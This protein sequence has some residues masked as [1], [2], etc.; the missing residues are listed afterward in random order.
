M[1]TLRDTSM[2]QVYWTVAIKMY[3]AVK[4]LKASLPNKNSNQQHPSTP[5]RGGDPI[6]WTKTSMTKLPQLLLDAHGFE[7]SMHGVHE[8]QQQYFVQWSIRPL[9]ELLQAYA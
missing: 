9:G 2:P 8:G 1:V 7:E 6:T 4:Y 3:F 5:Q